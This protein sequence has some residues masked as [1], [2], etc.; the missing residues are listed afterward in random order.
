MDGEAGAEA[1]GLTPTGFMEVVALLVAMVGTALVLALVLVIPLPIAG[2]GHLDVCLVKALSK[3][4]QVRPLA[5][6]T[7]LPPSTLV[8]LEA[9][10]LEVNRPQNPEIKSLTK[11]TATMVEAIMATAGQK[12]P[13]TAIATTL[14]R[15]RITGADLAVLSPKT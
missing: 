2:R 12:R 14:S 15:K 1:L 7:P 10:T 3:Q 13:V 8:Q 6:T 4:G 5:I 9:T 11:I